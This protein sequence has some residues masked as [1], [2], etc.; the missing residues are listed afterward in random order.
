MR[1][2]WAFGLRVGCLEELGGYGDWCWVE[3]GKR[4][5]VGGSCCVSSEPS[6]YGGEENSRYG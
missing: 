1:N 4:D 6:G 5:I 2:D 3:I